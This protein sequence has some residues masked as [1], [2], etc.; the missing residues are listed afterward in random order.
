MVP[1]ICVLH[2]FIRIHDVDDIPVIEGPQSRHQASALMELGGDIS[3]AERNATSELRESIAMAM[4]NSY[5]D[6]IATRNQ[7]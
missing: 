2:N 6:V 3:N 7:N 4:W 5:M 1:A